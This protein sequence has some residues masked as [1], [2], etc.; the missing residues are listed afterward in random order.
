MVW[1]RGVEENIAEYAI[2]KLGDSSAYKV[3]VIVRE[4]TIGH[5]LVPGY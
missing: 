3:V 5:S 2:S 1:G 4:S